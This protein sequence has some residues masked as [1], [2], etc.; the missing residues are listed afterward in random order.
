M[1]FKPLPNEKKSSLKRLTEEKPYMKEAFEM[2][3]LMGESRSLRQ[4]AKK[5]GKS[6]STISVWNSSFNWQERIEIRDTKVAKEFNKKMAETND[7]VVNMKANFHKMLKVSI[8]N[9]VDDIRR[10]NIKIT[11]IRELLEVM[12]FDLELLGEEDRRAQ[13]QMDALTGAIQ[14]SMVQFGHAFT[15]DGKDRID[16]AQGG[17]EDGTEEE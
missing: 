9:A 1:P 7:T 5:L 4:L 17:E 8:A 6:V 11:N 13:S 12:R 14:Q 15:Y 2:Y 10:G 16:Y 3:Y